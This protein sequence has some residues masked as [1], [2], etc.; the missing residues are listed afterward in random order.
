MQISAHSILI[1]VIEFQRIT[2]F[3]KFV[4]ADVALELRHAPPQKN[5]RCMV[6][7]RA[8]S[9]VPRFSRGDAGH[10]IAEQ[11]VEFG[12]EVAGEKRPLRAE[13]QR[14]VSAG[15]ARSRKSN[16]TRSARS[17]SSPA[18]G[19]SRFTRA[20]SDCCSI[21]RKARFEA[22]TISRPLR[23]HRERSVSTSKAARAVD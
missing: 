2:G 5:I 15:D 3:C 16:S 22:L 12:V 4:H 10:V 23:P 11:P 20:I 6:Q 19:C 13:L 8:L 17:S 1:A 7:D 14:V 18:S 9:P 21:T